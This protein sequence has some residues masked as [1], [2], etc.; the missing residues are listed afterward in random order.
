MNVE[1]LCP[2]ECGK[3]VPIEM[4]KSCT[5]KS[6][7]E[8][9]PHE[10][11]KIVPTGMWKSCAHMN[12]VRYQM[13]STLLEPRWYLPKVLR[14]DRPRPTAKLMQLKGCNDIC[15]KMQLK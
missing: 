11:G 5:H 10:C 2:Q 9:C 6:V 7:E 4:W 8:L 15:E 1:K 3:V 12:V 14:C 13:H